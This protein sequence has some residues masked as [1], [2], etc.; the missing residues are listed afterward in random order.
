MIE[1]E[2]DINT[3]SKLI[4]SR[5]HQVSDSYYKSQKISRECFYNNKAQNL[6]GQCWYN[7][8]LLRYRLQQRRHRPKLRKMYR[9]KQNFYEK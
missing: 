1:I 7:R 4:E 9:N 5:D 3:D 8:I 2:Q 6:T